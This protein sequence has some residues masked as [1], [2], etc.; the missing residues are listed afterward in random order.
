LLMPIEVLMGLAW[1]AL[2]LG[3]RLAPMQW[4][5]AGMIIGSMML[6]PARRMQVKRRRRRQA[7]NS[8]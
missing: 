6:A 1:A 3:E 2:L 5:A 7:S 8:A 4:L